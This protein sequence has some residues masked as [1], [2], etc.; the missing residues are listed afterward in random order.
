MIHV[1]CPTCAAKLKAPDAASGKKIPCP[2]CGTRV[3]V[4]TPP[5]QG[6]A[7]AALPVEAPP[8][9]ALPAPTPVVPLAEEPLE[10]FELCP[11]C[12]EGVRERAK[13]CRHCGETL[14]VALRAEEEAERRA[15]EEERRER[16]RELA[17]EEE[18]RCGGCG[19]VARHKLRC[20]Q[21]SGIYC[22]ELCLGR[23]AKFTGHVVFKQGCLGVILLA[24]TIVGFV[25]AA[26][27]LL[28][29]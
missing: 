4:P 25:S 9:L 6:L 1:A 21:C 18:Q 14:D 19:K 20:A 16:E 26:G 17:E 12:G 11:F 10:I 8:L 29:Q 13:R 27:A 22:C 5:L 28:I 24:V 23:H 15:E 7:P 3:N 2:K